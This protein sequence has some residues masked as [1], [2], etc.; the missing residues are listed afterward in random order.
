MPSAADRPRNSPNAL[1]LHFQAE[2]S[3]RAVPDAGSNH[4]L[5]SGTKAALDDATTVLREIDRPARSVHVEVFCLELTAKAG[6]EAGGIPRRWTGPS[7]SGT[8]REVRAKIRDL[9]QKGIVS[10]IKTV[11][12]TG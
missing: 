1:T 2:P 3:F 5:L 8:V 7:C 12:L 4:A 6:G 9:Q 10:S 11:E